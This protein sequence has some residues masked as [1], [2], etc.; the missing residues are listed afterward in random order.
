[1]GWLQA[2]LCLSR[3]SREYLVQWLVSHGVKEK[4]IEGGC[5]GPRRDMRRE[6]V[7][8]KLAQTR[9]GRGETCA[10]RGEVD[11]AIADFT[12]AI[13][14]EVNY[15]PAYYGR[16]L[17]HEKKGR[18]DQAIKDFNE[19]IWFSDSFHVAHRAEVAKF[20]ADSAQPA[21][22]YI[23]L[24][25]AYRTRARVYEKKGN[26]AKAGEDW[27]RAKELEAE[28]RAEPSAPAAKWE[29]TKSGRGSSRR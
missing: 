1:M 5:G 23:N 24:A 11:T 12:E 2:D 14:H 15:A 3:K 29:M 21:G 19:A 7:R 16:G 17:A 22:L 27:A 8:M 20:M 25:E 18:L 4:E 26:T 6:A 9:V 13:Q 10:A 28:P